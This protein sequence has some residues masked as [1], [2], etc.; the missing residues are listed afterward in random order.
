MFSES[1]ASGRKASWLVTF[2]LAGLALAGQAGAACMS[3]PPD[4]SEASKRNEYLLTPSDLPGEFS[5]KSDGLVDVWQWHVNWA[6]PGED[7]IGKSKTEQYDYQ[8]TTPTFFTPN[9]GVEAEVPKAEYAEDK[10]AI[11]T[12]GGHYANRLNSEFD[13]IKPKPQYTNFGGKESLWLGYATSKEEKSKTVEGEKEAIVSPDRVRWQQVSLESA[14]G[15]LSFILRAFTR[16]FAE[17]IRTL[18]SV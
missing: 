14:T 6:E 8:I 5:P 13:Y 1:K 2:G 10:Y 12:A 18:P 9:D 3:L 7:W 4:S 16:P 17:F 11:S 15:A